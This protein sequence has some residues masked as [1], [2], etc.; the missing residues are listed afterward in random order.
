MPLEVGVYLLR[1]N[2]RS[3]RIGERMAAGIRRAGDKVT[4]RTDGEYRGPREAVA[5]FY[6]FEKNTPTIMEEMKAAGRKAVYLDL[7]YWGRREGGRF[8]GYHK[9]AIN[10]RHPT[11]YFQN[12]AHSD[13]RVARFNLQVRPWQSGGGHIL[14]AGMSDRAAASLGMQPEE[15]ERWAIAEARKHTDRQIIYRPKPSWRTAKPILGVGFSHQ[16]EPLENAL[17]GCHA[18]V[19]HHSNVAVDAMVAGI[20]AFCWAGVAQP[21]TSQDLSQIEAPAYPD[22]REQWLADVAYCQWNG[23]EMENGKPWRHLK[24]EGLVP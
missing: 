10:D 22:D 4:I 18:V 5:V 17:A 19:T 13:D 9:I 12:T 6:G 24:G 20:P 3:Q 14:V 11:N 8:A 16:K 1:G 2:G 21:M 15:W 7:G 23:A